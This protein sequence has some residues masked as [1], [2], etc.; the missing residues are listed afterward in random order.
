MLGIPFLAISAALIDVKKGDLTLRVGIKEVHFS[1]SQCLKQHEVIQAKCIR[2]DN[3]ILG[4]KCSST[5]LA[6]PNRNP[7]DARFII[8]YSHFISPSFSKVS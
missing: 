8:F 4:C 5:R 6:D 7:R 1:L 2:I 3:A